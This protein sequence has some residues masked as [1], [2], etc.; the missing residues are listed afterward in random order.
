M[1]K[2]RKGDKMLTGKIAFVSKLGLDAALTMMA[3]GVCA[4]V[5]LPPIT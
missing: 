1:F 4:A 5:P 2:G 3:L